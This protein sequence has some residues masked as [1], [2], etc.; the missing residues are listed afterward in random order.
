MNKALVLAEKP[1]VARDIARVLNCQKANRNYLEGDRYVIT[2]ALGHLIELKMPEDYRPDYKTW[3]L[4]DLPII[5]DV[6]ETKPIKQT[7]SQFQAI[8]QLAKRSDLNELII[9]TDA[10]REGELVARWIIKHISWRKP[11]KRLWISSQTDRAVR[12]GFSH[13]KD[14]A[15][16][17]SLYQSAVCRSEADWLIG[18]NVSRALTVKYNDSLSAGRVQTPTLAMI[19]N[20]GQQIA[21]FQPQPYWTISAQSGRWKMNWKNG[22]Q[23]RL[24][25]P[26]AAERIITSLRGQQAQVI[27][28]SLKQKSEAQPLP[29]DLTELQREANRKFG[30][31]AKKTL[32]TLQALYERHKIVTYPR[33]DSRYLTSDIKATMTERLKAVEPLFGST[34]RRLLHQGSQVRASHVFNDKKVTDHHALIPT[35]EAP[36]LANLSSDE[37]ALYEIIVR[38]FL[39]LFYPNC[40]TEQRHVELLAGGEQLTISETITKAPGF[41]ALLS[42]EAPPSSPIV[43]LSRGE[44]L[45][46]DRVNLQQKMTEPP[47]LFSEADLLTKMENFGLGTPATRADIIEKLL[48]SELIARVSGGKLQATEKGRQLIGL[49]HPDLKTPQLTAR[50]EEKLEQ[51]AEGSGNPQQFIAKIKEQ[52]TSLINEI[53]SADHAYQI[54]NLTQ[55]LCPE[56]GSRMKEVRDRQGA[57]VLV[58]VNRS[59]GYRKHKDPKLSNHRCQNCHKKM[60]IHQGKSGPYFQCRT[61]GIV[62]KVEK[63]AKRVTKHETRHLMKKINQ[64][65]PFQNSLADL[66]KSALQKDKDE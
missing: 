5:P 38:R 35:E 8:R 2:W 16:F 32:N 44:T 60:E 53:R 61:C 25:D 36:A 47:A 41:R 40:L 55:S 6:M 11:I 26:R 51:I 29:Y 17:D 58:C 31:S 19:L 18:L 46:L 20:R 10:G 27:N 52:T 28:V 59:C 34:V 56:C 42:E 3:R 39:A 43:E 7:R 64:E 50:W 33:T 54:Q 57:R 9:A 13:L 48:Q 49:V 21:A 24:S 12:E 63:T 65:E 1:S 14:A 4:E 23:T 45:N 66:F 62:E 22:K 15:A 30:F 37:Y